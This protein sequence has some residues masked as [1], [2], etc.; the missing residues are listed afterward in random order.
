ELPFARWAGAKGRASQLLL[1]G[2]QLSG[3]VTATTGSP[4]N[5]TN[6]KSS[7]PSSRPDAAT[8]VTAV[9]SDYQ[10]TLRYLNPAEFIAVPLAAASGASIRPGNLGR[11]AFRAPGAWNLD[12]SLAKSFAV[13]ERVRIQLRGDFFNAFNHTNLGGLVTDISKSSF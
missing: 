11:F 10:Q 12:A 2:W 9:F 13:A 1:G 5:I 8:G 3:V 6:S 7:Y 4:V